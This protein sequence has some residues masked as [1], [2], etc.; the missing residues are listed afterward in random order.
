[1]KLE[2]GVPF[3]VGAKSGEE[4]LVREADAFFVL[5]GSVVK[6][7]FG[8]GGRSPESCPGAGGR[9]P[10]DTTTASPSPAIMRLVLAEAA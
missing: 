9:S 8:P 5:V 1:M 7:T 2:V 10:E 3:V 6:P 4:E